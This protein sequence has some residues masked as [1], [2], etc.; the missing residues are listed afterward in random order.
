LTRYQRQD[1]QKFLDEGST[2]EK[3]NF[4]VGSQELVREMTDPG[5][6]LYYD[7]EFANSVLRATNVDPGNPLGLGVDNDG[8]SVIGI[9]VGLDL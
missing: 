3:R 8:N 2:L 5:N 4:V 7:E 6:G 9:T 1:I